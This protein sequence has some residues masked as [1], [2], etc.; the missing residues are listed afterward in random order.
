[1]LMYMYWSTMSHIRDFIREHYKRMMNWNDPVKSQS[2]FC[3]TLSI[4]F[5]PKHPTTP[6]TSTV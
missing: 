3:L 5:V 2:H 1:M 4:I 6:T